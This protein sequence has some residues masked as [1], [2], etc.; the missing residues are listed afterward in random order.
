M[1]YLWAWYTFCARKNSDR[2]YW[3]TPRKLVLLFS[4]TRVAAWDSEHHLNHI[5]GAEIYRYKDVL[6]KEYVWQ[7]AV[8]HLH[9]SIPFEYLART[10]TVLRMIM[11]LR[12]EQTTLLYARRVLLGRTQQHQVVWLSVMGAAVDWRM[13][14][15]LT[16]IANETAN[17]KFIRIFMWWSAHTAECVRVRVR[18]R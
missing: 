5:P 12:Q 9:I 14:L 1:A 4:M 7:Q 18:T 8:L 2:I 13:K 15:L 16:K 3:H 17:H 10:I 6:K 11:W